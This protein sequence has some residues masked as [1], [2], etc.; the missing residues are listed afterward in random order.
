[1]HFHVQ[2]NTNGVISFGASETGYEAQPFPRMGSPMLAP[3]W[4][5]VDTLGVDSGEIRY[6]LTNDS[7]L[8]ALAIDDVLAVYPTFTSFT[9]TQLLIATWDRVRHYD[10]RSS[11]TGPVSQNNP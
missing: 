10:S 11:P 1:M 4:G 2:V 7:D 6:R 5:D 8:V 3:F 9:P